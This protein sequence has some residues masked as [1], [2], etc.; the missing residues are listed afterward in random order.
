MPPVYVAEASPVADADSFNR[1]RDKVWWWL[2][3]GNMSLC[4]QK[5]LNSGSNPSP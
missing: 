5:Q 4:G 1:R 2:V 3:A